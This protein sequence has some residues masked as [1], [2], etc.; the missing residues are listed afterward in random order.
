VKRGR[1][2]LAEAGE[3]HEVGVKLDARESANAKR[4]QPVRVL[5]AF[6]FALDCGA[7]VIEAAPPLRLARDD[8]AQAVGLN[9]D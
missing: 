1:E 2:R 3:H 5:Q 4:S 9:P 8:R 7:S 6:E